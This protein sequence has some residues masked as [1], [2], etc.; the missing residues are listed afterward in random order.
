M[1]NI[2]SRDLLNYLKRKMVSGIKNVTW[3]LGNRLT[4][5]EDKKKILKHSEN[6]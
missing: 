4:E 2:F 5:K 6:Y 1:F 3:G